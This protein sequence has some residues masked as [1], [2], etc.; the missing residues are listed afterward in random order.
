MRR[1]P[2]LFIL[3]AVI[4][5]FALPVSALRP[6]HLYLCRSPLL[7]FSFWGALQNL[8]RQGVTVTPKIA[9]EICDGMKAGKDPQRIRV[10]APGFK[11]IASG[12]DGALAMTDGKTRVWFHEPDR[13]GWVH[14]DYYV[15]YV[16][17][18]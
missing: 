10:D 5:L 9:Q 13:G 2:A 8:Q 11:P 16:N 6:S 7:A 14:P 4:L 1:S 3:C 18:K 17:S 12:A 15:Q